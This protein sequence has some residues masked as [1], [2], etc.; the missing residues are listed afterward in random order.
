MPLASWIP[1]GGAA[2]AGRLFFGDLS[3]PATTFGSPAAAGGGDQLAIL[4]AVIF[5]ALYIGSGICAMYASYEAYNPAAAAYRL[6]VPQ[7]DKAQREKERCAGTYSEAETRKAQIGK[8]M[9]RAPK[10][11]ELALALSRRA[12]SP[13][14]LPPI[15]EQVVTQFVYGIPAA[16]RGPAVSVVNVDGRSEVLPGGTVAFSSDAKSSTLLDDDHG[17]FVISVSEIVGRVRADDPEV[18]IIGVLEQGAIAAGRDQ[19]RGTLVFSD[20]GLSTKGALNFTQPGLLGAAPA[21]VVAFLEREGALPV[22]KGLSVFLAIGSVERPQDDLAHHKVKLVELLRMIAQ[23]G[24]AECVAVA[25][26]PATTGEPRPGLPPVSL[27]PVPPAAVF[28]GACSAVLADTGEVGFEKGQPTFL[29]PALAR[30]VLEPLGRAL[31]ERKCDRVVLTG[32]TARHGS[33]GSQRS[34]ALQ[35]AEAVKRELVTELGV[36]PAA[37]DTVGLG[38]YFIGYVPDNG[39]NGEL[40]PAQAQL[41]RT[42][43][44]D[45]CDPICP[46]YALR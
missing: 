23:K 18:D 13:E 25:E 29:Q 32:T 24:G 19:G 20:S 28:S 1:L 7:R 17:A 40:L 2:A 22:L 30:A 26:A 16:V 35:R 27:V 44:I 3:A 9:A 43:R 10:R 42:V 15:V 31:R 34:L 8:V 4:P 41:N 36:D 14:A 11:L 21:D 38:S 39:P 6:A 45:P 46:S 12:N 33:E 5:L 37:I